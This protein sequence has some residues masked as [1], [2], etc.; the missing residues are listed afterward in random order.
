M[1]KKTNPALIGAFVFGAV[2]LFVAAALIW[3]SRALFEHKYEYICYFPGSVNGLNRGA[4]VKYRGVEIGVVKDI[5]I[6]F[7]QAPDDTRIPVLIEAWGKRLRELGGE[8]EPTPERVHELIAKGLRA[9]LETLSIVTGVLYVSLDQVP[10]SQ[11]S[12]AELPGGDILEIPTLPTQMEEATK[13]VDA[14][15]SNLKATDF[16]GMADSIAH[17]ASGVN[18]LTA[19]PELR[20]ALK[21][22]P[23]LISAIHELASTLN[24]DA[25]KAGA[26]VDNAS[27]AM[28]SLR[29]TLDQARGALSPRAPLSVDLARAL[30]NMDKAAVA[31]RELADFLRRN[32]HSLV[33]GT[34]PPRGEQ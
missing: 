14:V 13:S 29:G 20:D 3:G 7:R 11:L 15:L 18:D 4:P 33:A 28:T 2:L 5:K 12:L 24:T 16:K 19:T 26:L 21:H 32:P 25:E 27:G 1:A 31:M 10:G 8:Q 9:R 34:K 23:Q 17:A 22:L 30:S 6:R